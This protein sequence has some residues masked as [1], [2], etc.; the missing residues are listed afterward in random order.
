MFLCFKQKTAYEMRISDWSSDV[1]SSDLRRVD[2]AQPADAPNA[3]A[4]I[5]HRRLVGAHPARSRKMMARA[6][7]LPDVR[8]QHSVV[9]IERRIAAVREIGRHRRRTHD[10]TKPLHPG[11][12]ETAVSFGAE[13]DRKNVV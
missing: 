6:G 8:H 4:R 11:E 13:I 2:D 12:D 7:T 3:Q 10:R 9:A 1:C 5:D